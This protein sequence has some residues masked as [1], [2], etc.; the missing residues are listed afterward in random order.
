MLKGLGFSV[1]VGIIVL[2]LETQIQT[3]IE[4]IHTNIYTH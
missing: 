3:Y 1:G 4:H 2:N